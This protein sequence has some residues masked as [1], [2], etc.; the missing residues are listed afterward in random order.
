MPNQ[1]T[2]AEFSAASGVADWRVL[3]WGAKAYFATADFAE[4]VRFLGRIAEVSAE[5]GHNPQVDLRTDS[6]TVQVLTIG[7]DSPISIS[8]SRG[9]SPRS[10]SSSG[11]PRT[12]RRCSTCSSPSTSPIR[13][14]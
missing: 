9:A 13:T 12:R 10:P 3:F 1:L 2:D 7:A 4:G 8:P 14:P 11:S 5:L 6:V